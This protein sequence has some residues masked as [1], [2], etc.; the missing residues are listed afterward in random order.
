MASGFGH[1]CNQDERDL[2]KSMNEYAAARLAAGFDEAVRFL[3][4][5]FVRDPQGVHVACYRQA[6]ERLRAEAERLRSDAQQ[7]S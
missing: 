2:K 5:S 1:I 7:E 3:A 6:I 4:I